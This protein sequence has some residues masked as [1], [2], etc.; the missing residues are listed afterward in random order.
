[1][2]PKLMLGICFLIF[3]IIGEIYALSLHFETRALVFRAHFVALIQ[4]F[5]YLVS[6]FLWKNL[7]DLEPPS[8]STSSSPTAN[9]SAREISGGNRRW[10]AWKTI[11]LTY[12][13][14]CHLSYLTNL[15]FIGRDPHWFAMLAYCSL[16]T[17]LQ[18]ATAMVILKVF[19]VGVRFFNR[20]TGNRS[21]NIILNK[22]TTAVL[23]SIYA[24]CAAVYGLTAAAQ[25]PQVKNVTIPIRGLPQSWQNT[26]IV[27]ISDIHLGPTVGFSKLSA[28]VDVIN[29]LH[30]GTAWRVW[31][32]KSL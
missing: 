17:Y 26:R 11:L 30:P 14:L 3:V 18:L 32:Q 28:I 23:A 7:V 19:T 31:L 20:S 5:L 24:V 9:S 25:V 15:V 10:T 22:R 27:Q 29:S 13:V 4:V 12:F 16:G 8:A 21:R 2:T 6:K 1:M